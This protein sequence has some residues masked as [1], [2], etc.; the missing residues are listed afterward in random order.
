MHHI[1]YRYLRPRKADALKRL[2]ETSLQERTELSVWRGQNATVLPLRKLE[3]DA[4][5]FGCGGVVDSQGNYVELSGH[6]YRVWGD[7]AFEN[8]EYRDE[9]VAFCG[10]LVNHWGHFLVESVARLWYV[11]EKDES[12]DKFV[13]FLEADTDREVAGNFREFLRLLNIWEKVEFV[14]T[15]TTY[16]EV[17]VPELAFLMRDYYSPRFVD[18]YDAVANNITVDPGWKRYSKIFFSRG[19]WAQN[20]TF[21]FGFESVDDFFRRNG[22]EILYPEK[23]PLPEFIYYMRNAEVV[24]TVSGSLPHNMLFAGNGQS[25][26]IIERYVINNFYQANINVMRQLQV[27]Y[28]DANMPVY[29]TS[30]AGPFIVGYNDNM[31]RFAADHGYVPP[32]EK[33]TTPAFFRSCFVKYMRL[34]EDMYQYQ[35]FMEGDHMESVDYIYEAY[36]AGLGYFGDYLTKKRPFLWHHYFEVHYWKQFIKRILRINR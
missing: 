13:F 25:L 20:R 4:L 7:Y 5:L 14:R 6:Q 19:Q 24:A 27:V 29:S 34:Y 11:L 12:I 3:G 8:P 32:S 23:I 21:E 22:Y 16:R 33:Y 30:M 18:V 28:I 35:W 2:H 17:V 1:D 36:Q 31:E 15:P 26:Q 10:Y 9:K